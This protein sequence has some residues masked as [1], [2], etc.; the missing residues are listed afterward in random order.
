MQA[1]SPS[2]P[3]IISSTCP[4]GNMNHTAVRQSRPTFSEVMS[5]QLATKLMDR[6]FPLIPV[7]QKKT[8]E[9]EDLELTLELSRQMVD[10]TTSTSTTKADTTQLDNDHLLALRLQAE[11]D[12]SLIRQ[13]RECFSKVSLVS[14][15]SKSELL[16]TVLD[17]VEDESEEDEEEVDIRQQIRL[18]LKQEKNANNT[19]SSSSD[20]TT[21]QQQQSV[22]RRQRRRNRI[23]QKHD[24]DTSNILNAA[25]LERLESGMNVGNL[26]DQGT[27]LNN[28]VYN[29][30]RADVEKLR[31]RRI[32]V[33]EKADHATSEQV[34][35]PRTRVMLLK[36]INSGVLREVNGVLATGKESRVYHA[37]GAEGESIA[38]KVFKTTLNEFRDREKYLSGEWRFR[39]QTGKHS[40]NPRKLI[41][42][43][44]EKELKNLKQMADSGL[45]TPKPILVRG[46]C[47]FMEFIGTDGIAAPRLR[48]VKFLPKRLKE[49]YLTIVKQMRTLYQ[50]CHLVHA[51]LSEFNILYHQRQAWFIDVAQSV[52]WDHPNALT[53]LQKDCSNI[54][55]FFRRCGID[56]CMNVRELFEFVTDANITEENMELYLQKMEE[57][58]EKRNNEGVTDEE[59]VNEEVFKHSFIPRTLA[60]VGDPQGEMDRCKEG[61]TDIFHRTIT[62]L[63]SN[64]TSVSRVPHALAEELEDEDEEDEESEDDDYNSSDD[65]SKDS[66]DSEDE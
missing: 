40:N 65:Y 28:K 2:S 29:S 3:S 23:Y 41:K 11:Y 24:I 39:F 8:H 57:L 38:I 6:E 12:Q 1:I 10:T 52:E 53:F 9:E 46:H 19:N 50:V 5:E 64:L 20:S 58:A 59:E 35:D 26:I 47:L 66:D 18:Q 42:L 36:F 31:S 33:K 48:D 4:W 21:Q 16:N 60:Q 30:L 13:Q 22:S 55:N 56:S 14:G 51:D 32:R 17:E 7:T 54:V 63:A 15:I 62:G 61:D 37:I 45:P 49:V 43:W 25:N 34:L 27:R 44:A